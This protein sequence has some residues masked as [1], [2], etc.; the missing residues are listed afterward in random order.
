MQLLWDLY[1]N[2]QLAV[3]ALI[4]GGG[5]L[6]AVLR[7]W[8]AWLGRTRTI[9]HRNEMVSTSSG[10][11]P[12][13]NSVSRTGKFFTNMAAG[14]LIVIGC[15]IAFRAFSRPPAPPQTPV[16]LPGQ[17]QQGVLAAGDP[18]AAGGSFVHVYALDVQQGAMYVITMRSH[19]FLVA[20]ILQNGNGLMLNAN[21]H[22]PEPGVVELSLV[23]PISERLFVLAMAT[24]PSSTGRYDLMVV[25]R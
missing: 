7:V 3:A 5:I 8:A 12:S 4:L 24:T 17:V 23:A 19:D 14:T 18:I 6:I 16:L 22:A 2:N 13:P 21:P 25:K 20:P 9:V 1:K 15:V 11:Q 10:R